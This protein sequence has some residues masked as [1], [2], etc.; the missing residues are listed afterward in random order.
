MS[1]D[2][3]GTRVNGEVWAAPSEAIEASKERAKKA[4][5]ITKRDLVLLGHLAVARYLT[6]SQIARLVFPCRSD[7]VVRRRL[8]VLSVP[9]ARGPF[10]AALK[11]RTYYGTPL[12]VWR[13]A[14]MGYEA[15]SRVLGRDVK[16]PSDDVG[17]QLLEHAIALSD[18]YVALATAARGGDG[19]TDAAPV[20]QSFRWTTSESS[21]LPWKQYDRKLGA[22]QNKRIEPDAILESAPVRR[23]WFIECEMGGHSLSNADEKSG[24]TLSK[25]RR[26]SEFYRSY[27]DG[28]TRTTFYQQAFPD[29]FPGELVFTVPTAARRDS[30]RRT[31]EE[32]RKED[33]QASEFSSRFDL[34]AHAMTFEE[35]PAIFSGFLGL[36]NAVAKP[37]STP[38]VVQERTGFLTD[39]EAIRALK[40]SAGIYDRLKDIR[41]DARERGLP[42]PAYPSETERTFFVDLLARKGL[43][44]LA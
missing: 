10:V 38:V 33:G 1:K 23:R 36:R 6:S 31:I 22:V 7:R 43:R 42:V 41:A 35:A 32:W 37:A 14:E 16:I 19:K 21:R 40:F 15:A 29:G 24:S 9:P 25:L 18:L 39:D 27:A 2:E 17:Y 8:E 28:S 12:A 30:V 13:L 44:R 3:D 20:H 4:S 11:Y 26:Y 34:R 5:R